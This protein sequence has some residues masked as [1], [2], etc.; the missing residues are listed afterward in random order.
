MT[1]E[2][3]AC[4]LNSQPVRIR[5]IPATVARLLGR[6][7]PT[8][9]P[10]LVEVLFSDTVPRQDVTTTAACSASSCTASP[11]VSRTPWRQH[12][13]HAIAVVQTCRSALAW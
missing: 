10:E 8:L 5:R 7:M 1:M 13:H 4:L 3:F 2:E 6:V 12:A 9:T 11:Q